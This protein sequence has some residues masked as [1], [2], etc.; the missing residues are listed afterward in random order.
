MSQL[1]IDL[2]TLRDAGSNLSKVKTEFE[3]AEQAA[4]SVGDAVKHAGMRDALEEFG[5]NWGHEREKILKTMGGLSD[6]AIGIADS[7]KQLDA[8][9]A[10]ELQKGVSNGNPGGN[11]P[12]GA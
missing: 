6:A 1:K 11:V 7:F 5:R 12:S 8:D 4:N 2:P 10:A 9:L 3:G